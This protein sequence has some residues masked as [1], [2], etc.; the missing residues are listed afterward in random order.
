MTAAVER[1]RTRDVMLNADRCRSKAA[2]EAAMYLTPGCDLLVVSGNGRAWDLDSARAR[3]AT[4][5]W[6]SRRE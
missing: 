5:G 4:S 2:G 3:L 6:M 1:S